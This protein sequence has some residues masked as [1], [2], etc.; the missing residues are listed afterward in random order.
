MVRPGVPVVLMTGETESRLP[1]GQQ[2]E[3]PSFLRKPFD[4]DEVIRLIRTA[5]PQSQQWRTP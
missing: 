2:R 3:A 5:L 4:R 1:L